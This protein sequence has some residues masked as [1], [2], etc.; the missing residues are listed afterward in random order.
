MT[1]KL[2]YSDGYMKECRAKVTR[3]D[4]N[5]V[6][7]DRSIF[8]P[9]CGGQP[10][11]RGTFGPY[12][13]K[14]TEKIENEP[15]H[16]FSSVEGLN[17]GDE[18]T[19][20]L[21]WPHRHE[22]MVKHSAQH[23]ISSLFY[24]VLGIGTV[25]VHLSDE[26]LTIEVDAPSV[27]DEDLLRIEDEANR[28]IREDHRIWQVTVPRAEAEAAH[29][30]RS[31]KVDDDEVMLVYIDGLDVVACGGVHAA[32]TAEIKEMTYVGTEKIR[33]R[34]RTVWK[35][36]EDSVEK[37][38]ADQ[39]TVK[40]LS[41]MLSSPEDGIIPSV[42]ALQEKEYEL[43]GRVKA[44]EEKLVRFDCMRIKEGDRLFVTEY[45]LEEVRSYLTENRISGILCLRGG[46]KKEFLFVGDDGTFKTMKKDLGLRGGGRNGF[47]Q[48]LYANEIGEIRDWLEN[49]CF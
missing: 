34:V 7:L 35:C 39:K 32:S 29:L 14:D 1:E 3:I 27:P 17:V 31:I 41:V 19:L 36:A 8:Y 43:K 10:G 11:D 28:A 40:E 13:I 47:Y 6:W 21:D 15:A 4:G 24:R 44:L 2:Y 33:G 38:R 48:G 12:E 23:L 30:R 26:F 16:I 25:A 42:Q 20:T 5:R 9:E 22:F 49:N 18:C 45:P 46:E 37:R